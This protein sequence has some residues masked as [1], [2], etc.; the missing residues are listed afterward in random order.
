ML[1]QIYTCTLHYEF[2]TAHAHLSNTQVGTKPET[3]YDNSPY[4][5]G[6]ISYM[7]FHQKKPSVEA[8]AALKVHFSFLYME[9][10]S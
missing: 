3:V 5:V 10:R 2:T 6:K 4:I 7:E 1:I 8:S 9:K